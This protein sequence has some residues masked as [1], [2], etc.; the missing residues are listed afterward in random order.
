[1]K[2]YQWYVHSWYLGRWEI[3]FDLR[4][5]VLGFYWRLGEGGVF[6]GPIIICNDRSLIPW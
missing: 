1:M 6:V 4:R 3:G 2:L 5:W